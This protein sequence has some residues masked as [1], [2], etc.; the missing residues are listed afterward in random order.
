MIG[1]TVPNDSGL[2][3]NAASILAMTFSCRIISS[4]RRCAS[5]LNGSAFSA[6]YEMT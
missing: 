3:S 5:T 2:Y 4:I 1:H 6:S